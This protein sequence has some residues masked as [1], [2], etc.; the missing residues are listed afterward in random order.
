MPAYSA[1]DPSISNSPPS[2]TSTTMKSVTE[3]PAVPRMPKWDMAEDIVISGI[4]G[5]FPESDNMAEFKD[6]LFN[7]VDMITEDDRRWKPGLYGLPTRCGKLKDLSKFDATFFGVHPKQA[8]AMDPQLRILL[9]LTYEAIVDAGYDPHS[10]RGRRTGVF[11]GCSASETDEA[12]GKDPEKINGYGL[13]G[14]CRSMF[15]NRI[16]YTFDFKGPSFALDTACSS[17][18]L[19]LDQAVIALRTS[20]CEAAIVGGV[21]LC[22][23]PTSSLQ[24]HR[25]G[26]LSVDGKCKAFDASGNG[27]VRSEAASV[28]FLQRASEARRIYA[29]VVHVKTNTD[30]FKEQGVT[31]PAGHVQQELLNEVYTEA[32]LSANDVVYVEAHGTG[33]KV[34]DPQELGAIADVLCKDRDNP[35]LIGSVKSNMGHSEPASGLCSVAKVLVAMETGKIPANLHFFSPN[36]NIPALVD[37]RLKVVDDNLTLPKGLIAINSFG[38][39]GANV[40]AVLEPYRPPS[41]LAI[42]NSKSKET[43]P[44]LV[45]F[46]GRTEESVNIVFNQLQEDVSLETFALLTEIGRAPPTAMPYRGFMIPGTDG[47]DE[48]R[49]VE[50]APGEKRPV[51][52]ICSG[53]G[54]QWLGMCRDMMSIE[55]FANSLHKTAGILSPYGVDLLR[56]V[57]DDTDQSPQGTVASFVSIAAVQVALIDVLRSLGI[58]PDGIVGHSVGELGCAYADGCFTAEQT[59]LAAYWRGRCVEEAD[60]PKGGMAAVGLTWE[61]TKRR[62]PEGVIPACHNAEDTVTISGPAE[63]VAAFVEELK[64]ENIFAR[65]VATGGIAFHSPYMVAITGTLTRALEKIIKNPLPRSSRWISS[66]IPQS[67]W[68]EPLAQLSSVAYHMNNL[69]TP[70]LFH[71]ALQ[72]V[73]H[74]AVTIEIA[75]HCLLQSILKRT[76]GS[77]CSFI[78]LMK[79]KHHNNMEFFLSSIGKMYMCGLNPAIENLYP[80]VSFPVSPGTPMLSPLVQWDHSQSWTVT[81]WDQFFSGGHSSESIVEIDLSALDSPD[82]YLIGHCIDGRVLF[83]ATGYMLLA[84]KALAR[85]KGQTFEQ[86]PVIFENVSFHRATILPK[87]GVVRLLVN[88]MEITGEFEICEGGAVAASGR[89]YCPDDPVMKMTDTVLPTPKSED[90]ILS[91]KDIYTELRLRGYDYGPTFQGVLESDMNGSQGKLKWAD[92]WVVFLDTMLQFSILGGRNRGL[93]LPT[94]LQSVAINPKVHKDMADK[95][96]GALT[97]VRD[98]YVNICISG[99]VE[100]KGIKASLAPRRQT[101]QNVPL[102]EKYTFIP[103]FDTGVNNSNVDL[104]EYS[105]VCSAVARRI[106]EASGKNKAQITDVLNGFTEP[107]DGILDNYIQTASNNHALLKVLTEMWHLPHDT[108]F[109]QNAKNLVNRCQEELQ[110][111]LLTTSVLKEENLR[112]PLDTVLENTTSRKLKIVEVGSGLKSICG[113]IHE[114]LH[115]SNF[116]LKSDYIVA[117]PNVEAVSNEA[118]SA[119]VKSIQW[120]L[121][122]SAPAILNDCDLLVAWDILSSK[123]DLQNQ[124]ATFSSLLKESGFML[125]IE[126]TDMTPAER[127]LHFVCGVPISMK[128]ESVLEEI[129]RAQGLTLISHKSAGLTFSVYLLRRP[130]DA[131]PSDQTVI[132]VKTGDYESWV[133]KLKNQLLENQQKPSCH[134]IWLVSDDATCG[135]VGMT[136]CLRQEP[137]G[138]KLRCILITDQIKPSLSSFTLNDPRF[139]DV[140]KKDLVMNVYKNRQWGSFRHTSFTGDVAEIVKTE[141]ALLN[142]MT[143]GD[144][145]SLR[146]FESPL[147]YSHD[148]SNERQ[149][150]LCYVYYAPLNFRDIM[151]ATGKLPPDALPGNLAMEDCILGLEFAGRNEKGQRVMGLVPAKGLATTVLVDPDFLWMVPDSWTLEEAST[152]PVAYST[153]YYA[154]VVRGG[155][156]EGES[157][158]VHSGSGGVGQAAISIALHMECEVFTTV[159]S[160]EKREYLKRRFPQLTDKN[161]SNSRDLSF[162]YDIMKATNGKGVN[163]ILN[164]LAEEKLQ[165]SVRCLAQHGRFLEIGKFDLS[166]NSP[167]GMSAFLRNISFHGILLDA[168]FGD[169]KTMQSSK[170]QIVQLVAKGIVSGAVKPLQR[171]LFEKEQV[172]EA[173]RYMAS[174]KHIGKVVIKI[175]DEE[176]QKMVTPVPAHIP[177]IPRTICHPKKSYIVIGGLGGFGLEL[178][179]WLIDRGARKVVVTSRSGVRTG[180][181]YLCLQR[182]NNAGVHVFVSKQNVVSLENAYQLLK[183]SMKLGSVGGIFNVAAVLRDAFMENQSAQDFKVV[184]EPKADGTSNLDQLSREMCPELDWFVVFSSVSCGRGNAGQSNYGFANSV[185]ER[186]CEERKKDGYP[187]LAVQWGAIGDVGLVQETMGG[188]DTVIGGTIP[189]RIVS[190]LA[191][192][193]QF[194]QQSCP[195]VSSIVRA[196]Q[197][198]VSA[199]DGAGKHNLIETVARILGV[200]DPSTLNPEVTLGELGMDSLMG[201]E[202]KQTLERDYDLVMSMQEIRQLNLK[203][204]EEIG[205][206]VSLPGSQVEKEDTKVVLPPTQLMPKNCTVYLNAI[207]NGAPLFVVHTIEGF[208]SSM[209]N[210]ASL[211]QRPVIGLQCTNDVPISSIKE[212]ASY[213]LKQ[214][215]AIQQ[216]GP[217]SIAGY[218]FGAAVAFEIALQLQNQNGPSVVKSLT[219]LDGSPTFVGAHLQHYKARVTDQSDQHFQDASAVCAYLMNIIPIDYIKT[220]AEMLQRLSWESKLQLATELLASTLHAPIDPQEVQQAVESFYRRL[221]IADQY[222]PSDRY[223]GKVTLI[224]AAE[225]LQG[226]AQLL[227]DYGLS[228]VCEGEVDVYTVEGT[229]ETFVQQASATKVAVILN[230]QL[231]S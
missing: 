194:L 231:N 90:A 51:W 167:L 151:L 76:L 173:F 25:L 42:E 92:N 103:Y 213:Y 134:N 15:A 171:A 24:F 110:K 145:S 121:T 69:V 120:D 170:K 186:I 17:S 221:E 139:S 131:V 174:G 166:K 93:F 150:T 127:F 100:M 220:K 45:T 14:C 52:Y 175:K 144:L 44:Y 29:T 191:I 199:G 66:S 106:L 98:K 224:K 162:E 39:G 77:E 4:S 190:C 206:E 112:V 119:G 47:R 126:R 2:K 178:I 104:E 212:M 36:P 20:Q 192:L 86:M 132:Q 107:T 72:H 28:V 198:G 214:I 160:K 222:K 201:V 85:V 159:G 157:V 152:V 81:T 128:K 196:E 64:A 115:T 101:Q 96:E 60:F 62:C 12:L 148:L 99:G 48:V 3:A 149:S 188:N 136:N 187:A 18:L 46:C 5:R 108:N 203:T 54:T 227:H 163:L 95:S 181:Q 135:I 6:N 35:L 208:V 22:L 219:L 97:V 88:V 215:Q 23:K 43:I 58:E 56:I 26:M 143:R 82:Q 146:W 158:L 122:S 41:N 117:H 8:H 11:I 125:V 13:T 205:G 130:S 147:K 40:H 210:V 168:L 180:Y 161:F 204:L 216:S 156:Q 164:S 182:W 109:L 184:C 211:L 91:S 70:V 63:K 140:L 37:G 68:K 154:L 102:L 50:R 228:E 79:R 155:L 124:V 10:L 197:G 19:A 31:F 200:K 229:H 75:P 84:W 225:A 1:V 83:P 80:T 111:D 176:D 179:Q 49:M 226:A 61:E 129:F 165:A 172:E 65:E 34:G 195:V 33:T 202:V 141:H 94:R 207:Q 177:V 9:E 89:V 16:S 67:K 57:T 74:N 193:D 218:S 116:L 59:V 123:D 27:Y 30:G 223:I 113:R 133:E 142:V 230:T 118:A 189:Q 71:E 185:M 78:G 105:Q 153:A 217:Y 7:G 53:M 87:N 38:F 138:N 209:N 114:L 169:D 32:G 21:N 55:V 183:D 137:G 73:P